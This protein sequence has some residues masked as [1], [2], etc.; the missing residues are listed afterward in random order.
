MEAGQSARGGPGAAWDAVQG[1]ASWAI[2]S[3]KHSQKRRKNSSQKIVWRLNLPHWYRFGLKRVLP[4]P[5]VMRRTRG[6]MF[7]YWVQKSSKHVMSMPEVT[8]SEGGM[9]LGTEEGL[10]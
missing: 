9:E 6:G 2:D 8:R 5:V 7:G 4:P 3:Q 10:R 1:L